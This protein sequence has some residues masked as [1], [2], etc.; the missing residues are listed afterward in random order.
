MRI[1]CWPAVLVAFACSK[2]NP[3]FCEGHPGDNCTVDASTVGGSCKTEN[4]CAT[5]TPVC[6]TT[7]GTCVACTATDTRACTGT[8]PV[9][10]QNTCTACAAHPEC[11]SNACL[12]T[13]ACGDDASVAYVSAT[14]GDD[15]G[16]CSKN[17]PCKRL[18]VAATKGKPYVKVET[19]L[20]EAVTIGGAV[21]V[22]VLGAP[23]VRLTRTASPG[24]IVEVTG[25]A[26][27]TLEDLIIHGGLG[28]TG[29]GLLVGAGQP[30]TVKLQRVALLDN[31]GNGLNVQGGSL[32]VTRSIVSGNNMGGAVISAAFDITNTLFA[33]NGGN[34]ST[35][36]GLSILSSGAGD[37]FRFNTIASNSSSSGA[38]SVRGMN[39]ALMVKGASSIVWNNPISSNCELDYSL[40]ETA[41]P[42]TGMHNKVGNPMFVTDNAFAPLDPGYFR[43]GPT[44]A[45]ID[46]GEPTSNVM[47]DID[48]EDRPHGGARDIGADEYHGN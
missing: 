31:G 41:V 21:T 36:G 14:T 24:A 17:Q 27:V 2:P 18:S 26:N 9:C 37:V 35:T 45:A 8:T 42:A 6:D 5:P 43:I 29:H 20:D 44:S 25:T 4:D 40:F 11:P 47:H 34:T 13:G 48:G 22:T 23:G 19:D 33:W 12:P 10:V 39:C 28:T 15:T 16:P 46:S 32:V 7:A 30:A 1:S 38:S 3:Y